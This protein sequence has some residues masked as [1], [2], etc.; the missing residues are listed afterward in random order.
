MFMC[1][2]YFTLGFFNILSEDQQDELM[3]KGVPAVDE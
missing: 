3:A 2:S 1:S